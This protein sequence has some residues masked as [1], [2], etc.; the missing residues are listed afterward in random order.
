LRPIYIQ[1]SAN[2]PNAGRRLLLATFANLFGTFSAWSASVAPPSKRELRVVGTGF[3]QIFELSYEGVFY[4]MGVEVVQIIAAQLGYKVRFEIFPW[5]RAL[6]LV[7]LGQADILIGPYQSAERMSLMAFSQQPF[8]E[9]QL[10]FYSHVQKIKNWQGDYSHLVGRRILV[11]N[12]WTYGNEFEMAR[13]DLLINIANTVEG[14]LTMLLHQR[15]DLLAANRRDA[16]PIIAALGIQRKIVALTPLIGTKLA[17]L[18][19][20]RSAQH[21]LIRG[22]FDSV[23]NYMSKNGV[24][25]K[26][27]N[28]YGVTVP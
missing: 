26:L 16:D 12:G 10:A 21:D 25:K 8:F 18:A 24:L 6:R 1:K 13:P 27:G 19:Y 2:G 28:R 11:L 3:K 20:P 23:L 17:F 5:A 15:A 7:Q 4:G 9:D 14:A 22:E